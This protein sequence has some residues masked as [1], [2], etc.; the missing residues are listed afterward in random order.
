MGEKPLMKK[1]YLGRKVI[2]ISN[3]FE[4]DETDVSIG[5]G[6]VTGFYKKGDSC[7]PVVRFLNGEEFITFSTVIEYNDELWGILGKLS[8]VERWRLIMAVVNRF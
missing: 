4:T 5:I 6:F 1:Y 8:P 7:L 2:C 3:G